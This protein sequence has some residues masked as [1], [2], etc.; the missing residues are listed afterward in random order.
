MRIF[1]KRDYGL[2]GDF[3]GNLYVDKK[4]FYKR[5]EVIELIFKLK[6]SKELRIHMNKNKTI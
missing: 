6:N 5:P 1:K 4:I 3:E 2:R